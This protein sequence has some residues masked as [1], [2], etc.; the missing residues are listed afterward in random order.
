MSLVCLPGHHSALKLKDKYLF[1]VTQEDIH[2]W[3]ESSFHI[4]RSNQVF[5]CE[6]RAN[7]RCSSLVNFT[8]L[9]ECFGSQHV[10]NER[11]LSRCLHKS[12]LAYGPVTVCKVKVILQWTKQLVR[13]FFFC[14]QFS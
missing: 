11:H 10:K 13:W 8:V 9:P 12:S 3:F 5:L 4:Q 1:F 2:D 6:D 14:K 7:L